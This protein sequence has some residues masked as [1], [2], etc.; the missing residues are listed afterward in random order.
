MVSAALVALALAHSPACEAALKERTSLR[1]IFTYLNAGLL[2]PD[3]N[4]FTIVDVEG[5]PGGCPLELA[6]RWREAMQCANEQALSCLEDLN[7]DMSRDIRA[8]FGPR[9]DWGKVFVTCETRIMDKCNALAMTERATISVIS[10]FL[11]KQMMLHHPK[12]SGMPPSAPELMCEVALHE[13][14]HW[15]GR[16]DDPA[17]KVL[18]CGRYC[19]GQCWSGQTLG[20]KD[21]L[22]C[23]GTHEE[24]W[25]CGQGVEYFEEAMPRRVTC[26]R[27]TCSTGLWVRALACDGSPFLDTQYYDPPGTFVCC[28]AGCS[29]TSTASCDL[30]APVV[31][32]YDCPEPAPQCV[33]R[34]RD[35]AM[36]F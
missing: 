2:H 31:G 21:C 23:A 8:A 33:G 17:D 11:D 13:A 28:K 18:A 19:G 9:K 36:P 27:S 30:S 10:R 24:K 1:T 15:S 32:K 3:D 35:G 7:G 6:N 4:N 14:A 5:L 16:S 20:M 34:L 26:G 12:L 22:A 25:A 29:P